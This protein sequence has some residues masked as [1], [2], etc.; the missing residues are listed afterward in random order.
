MSNWK[1]EYNYRRIKDENGKVIKNVVIIDG[2]QIEVNDEV[3]QVYSQMHRREVY[4]EQQIEEFHPISL[5]YLIECSVPIDLYISEHSASAE[6]NV[7]N[8]AEVTEQTELLHRLTEALKHL[9][10][11]EQDVIQALYFTGISL[12]EY[13]KTHGIPTMTLHYR[14]KKILKKLKAILN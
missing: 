11:D 12:R 3:Y 10:V 13:S 5:D 8:V 1:D 14:L 4:Q 6:E 2:K 9:T 7:I